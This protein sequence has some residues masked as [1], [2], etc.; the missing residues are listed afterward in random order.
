MRHGEWVFHAE[1]SPD[2]GRVITASHDGTARVWDA[3][4]GRPITPASGAMG[5]AIAV[6]DACFSPDGG[7]VATAGYDGSGPGLGCSDRRAPL[8]AALPR[9]P[10]AACPVHAGRFAGVDRRLRLDRPALGRD[11]DRSLGHHHRARRRRQSGRLRS[12][13]ANGSPPRAATAPPGSGTRRPASRSR[14]SCLTAAACSASR[15]VATDACSR[16][17]ALTAPPAS[18]THRPGRPLTPPFVHN[19]TVMWVAFSPDGSRL[20]TASAD[21]TARIWDVATGQPVAPS[22]ATQGRGLSSR[23]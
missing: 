3:R 20:A 4:T 7:R 12:C 22:S 2:G 21:G 6:R 23:L 19:D 11:H 17:A 14:R 5:H 16:P 18:G 15:F 8:A 13:A 10:I 1:F 9:R